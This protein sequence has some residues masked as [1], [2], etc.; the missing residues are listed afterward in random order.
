[1]PRPA[2]PLFQRV[3]GW[4]LNSV[5]IVLTVGLT[6]LVVAGVDL[7]LLG[8]V[9]PDT[10]MVS[11]VSG[12]IIATL[13]VST[14]GF[15]RARI[16]RMHRQNLEQGIAQ[17][18]SHLNLAIETSRMLYWELNLPS[19]QLS[20]D[21]AKMHWLG[22][23]CNAPASTI[24]D[25][26]ALIHP[27]DQAG[28][29]QQFQSTLPVGA[30]DFAFDYRMQQATGGWGWVHSLGRI[31][32]RGPQGEPLLA[33]GGTLSIT[34]RKQAEIALIAANTRLEESNQFQKTLMD[35]I[36]IPIFYQDEQGRLLGA[37]SAYEIF[38]GQPRH[39]FVGKTVFDIVPLRLAEVYHAQN[40][41]LMARRET[42]VYETQV[43]DGSGQLRDVV[44][45]KAVFTD[46]NNQV[47][48]IIGGLQDVTE[49]K[50]SERELVESEQRTQAL[51]TLLR[52]VA[53]NV[54]DMIWAKDT[55][56]RYLFANKAVCE[57]LLMARDTDEPIGRDDL[58]FAARERRAHPDRPDW[59]TFGELC[60]D[61]DALTLQSGEAAQFD[62]FGNVQGK[63]LFLD[64]HKA[65]LMGE[66]GELV[67]V[68]GSARDVTAEREAQEKL[69]VAAAVLANSSEAL[70]LSDAHNCIV[71]IN[72]AFTRLTGYTLAEVA[73]KNPG[74]LRS[75]EQGDDFHHTLWTQ[76]EASG[77]WQGE[78]WNRRK[79]GEVF[80][81][82]L[83]INTLYHDD[84]SVHRRVGLFS[85]I[86]EK[87]SCAGADLDPGQF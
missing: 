8:R 20:F 85:D 2:T 11:T 14:A 15:V 30:P 31:K 73:G 53:D 55:D 32:D 45:L 60:Q 19:G 28:F 74:F 76:V 47:R 21:H 5:I 61:S 84:G 80:A 1:M 46:A 16:A 57:Q 87:K 33:V 34:Q 75:D 43:Q 77:H 67:G 50:E 63:L 4:R 48:G 13:V 52:M 69:R 9:G 18:Q 22:L 58:Y 65:P 59:H 6:D 40:L 17:A 35:A 66:H 68:V 51:Y 29:M 70:M 64:V 62:E 72:P 79:D 82:W 42:L 83:T 23:D 10:L 41:A 25:W 71:D 78:V 26:L 49:R 44:F 86:T 54:P 38:M 3:S 24:T 12:L 56:R 39:T 37:N 81:E 36:P 27:D 7:L